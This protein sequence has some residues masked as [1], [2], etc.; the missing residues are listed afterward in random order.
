MP[1][2]RDPCLTVPHVRAILLARR[3]WLKRPAWGPR[4]PA[5]RLIVVFYAFSREVA[6]LKRRLKERVPLN[7]HGL[8]GFRAAAGDGEIA[9][10][11]TGIGI[12]RAREVARH[13]LGVFP[14]AHLV[15]GTGVVGALSGGL[16]PGDIVV[17]D[18]VVK[19][20]DDGTHPEHVLAVGAEELERCE[21]VLRAAGLAFS[22]GGILTSSRVLPDLHSKRLAK[23]QSGAIAVDMES[24]AIALE[25]AA[26]GLPF[27]VVRTVMDSL[28]DE[29]FGAEVADERGRIRP[30]AATSYLV[31]NPGTFLKLPRMLRNLALAGKSL[32]DA[33]EALTLGA[34]P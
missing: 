13:A 7:R 34:A 6:L 17:A 33:I 25:A 1:V 31:R 23:E 16:R 22:T 11:A 4:A 27:V 2:R 14:Q 30:L 28:E 10:I 9:F 21:R 5:N 15:I 19:A 8:K 20:G 26:R 12:A 18:R 32:A 24:V 29:V 3:P